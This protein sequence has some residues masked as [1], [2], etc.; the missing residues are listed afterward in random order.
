MSTEPRFVNVPVLVIKSLEIDEPDWC[1]DP[2]TSAQFRPDITHNGP[3][4]SAHIETR[5]G[6]EPFL[7]AW[8]SHAPF[9][10]LAPEPLPVLAVDAGGDIL[11]FDPDSVRDFTAT[12]RAHLDVLDQL[13]T[14]LERVRG[15]GR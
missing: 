10:E 6:P 4:V 11:N 13:A 9:S 8:I 14:E 3:E 12:V 5:R 15:G 7:T 2:H 1:I